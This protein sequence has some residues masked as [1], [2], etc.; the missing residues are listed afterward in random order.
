LTI[1]SIYEPVQQELL[2]VEENLVQVARAAPPEIAEIL[3]HVLQNGGKR[4]RPAI[5]LLTGKFYRYNTELLL[6][7]A[8]AVELLH[9]ATLVHDDSIDKSL[10]RR[11]K[12]TINS[13]WGNATALLLGDYLFGTSALIAS[14]TD[15]IR[16]IKLFA[17]TLVTVSSGEIGQTLN[18]FNL[19]QTRQS[20]FKRIGDKTAFLFSMAAESGAVLSEAPEDVVQHLKSY[21]YNLGIG[22]QIVDD[23][24]DLTGREETM[25]KP[26]GSDLL[27]GTL[28]LPTILLL[29]RYP[30]NNPVER[31]FRTGNQE[32]MKLVVQMILDSPI[33]EECYHTA[34]DFCSQA[35]KALEQLPLNTVH[36]SLIDLANYVVER[37]K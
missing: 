16:L 28:T 30:E 26:V 23:V 19:N 3:D 29:E 11:A 33:V 31:I 8:T 7:M 21:A 13:L 25:G 18:S 37:R 2:R 27:Q 24:L 22:F 4:V 5:T 34:Q 14:S 32:D 35:C 9:T 15:N 6:P 36:H 20:Y 12:P 17:Q 1:S 10:W